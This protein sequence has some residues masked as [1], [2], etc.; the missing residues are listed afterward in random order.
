MPPERFEPM[1]HLP[2]NPV[3]FHFKKCRI[4]S[5]GCREP[6]K[7][8]NADPHRHRLNGA[9]RRGLTQTPA[10]FKCCFLASAEA[11]HFPSGTILIFKFIP[12]TLP[13]VKLLNP[14][15]GSFTKAAAQKYSLTGLLLGE[16]WEEIF[17][18]NYR[19][20]GLWGQTSSSGQ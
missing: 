18:K 7:F 3:M 9:E 10:S 6:N 2:D 11:R 4:W 13:N 1:S 20:Q 5:F 8:R 19:Q 15:P 17:R 16:E 14:P 12:Q